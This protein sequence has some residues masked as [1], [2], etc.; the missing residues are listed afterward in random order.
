M[1]NVEQYLIN[2]R[3]VVKLSLEDKSIEEI[4]KQLNLS[5]GKVRGLRSGLG[6]N[7][8][9]KGINIFA[10][11]SK[12]VVNP[13]EETTKMYFSIPSYLKDDLGIVD[14]KKY[15]LTGKILGKGKIE[16]TI[17]PKI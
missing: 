11:E 4:A 7:K 14:G 5:V 15:E 2:A 16:L 8:G 10:N 9:R 3:E 13:A 12:M 17:K 1:T 6:L